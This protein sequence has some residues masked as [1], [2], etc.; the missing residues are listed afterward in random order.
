MSALTVS[1]SGEERLL[2]YSNVNALQFS[3]RLHK[4]NY[5]RIVNVGAEG[6]RKG[7][8]SDM[9]LIIPA[10]T[11][12]SYQYYIHGIWV[13]KNKPH[14][15]KRTSLTG[16]NLPTM[17][18]SQVLFSPQLHSSES[19]WG[20][21]EWAEEQDKRKRENSICTVKL[22]VFP[23]RHGEEQMALQYED[24]TINRFL[25]CGSMS[26]ELHWVMRRRL[27]LHPKWYPIPYIVGTYKPWPKVVH[28]ME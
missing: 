1:R 18:G 24:S 17:V 3:F 25:H 28:Y 13:Q 10:H 15:S 21:R 27:W 16:N 9:L 5:D 19:Q 20:W 8:I 6:T 23:G 12:Q 22:M 4:Y 11:V 2:N 14:A 26:V 7:G